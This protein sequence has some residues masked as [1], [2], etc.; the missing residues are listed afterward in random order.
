MRQSASGVTTG[1]EEIA[2]ANQDLSKRTEEQSSSLEETAA[3]M[4]QMTKTLSDSSNSATRACE[5]AQ[6]ADEKAKEGGKVVSSAVK[7]MEDINQ[8]SRKI[9]EIISVI[10]VLAFQ[11]NL[12]ALNASVEAARAGDQGRGFAVVAGEVRS[13]AQRCATAAKEIKVL[14]EDSVAKVEMGSELIN[15]SG[16]T[17]GDIQKAVSDVND[18]IFILSEN[19][20]EQALG[21][22]QVN[23]AV[24]Q[25]DV[26]TQQ[27]ATMVEQT[28]TASATMASQSKYMLSLLSF[29]STKDVTPRSP[30]GLVS[31]PEPP[32]K[33]E[34]NNDW[35]DF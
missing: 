1:A 25:M 33:V 31:H 32:K 11:T 34:P 35:D 27:N 8:S 22:Q 26:M 28:A 16:D 20:S 29:F 9:S 12:L 2:A 19:A 23:K 3:S 5:L 13:L 18:I 6:S 24:N 30:L 10:D 4:E 17:L 14:I 21:I 15:R 7:A